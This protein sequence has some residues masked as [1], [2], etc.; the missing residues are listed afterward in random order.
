MHDWFFK[1]GRK[2]RLIDW[3]GI[4]DHVRPIPAAHRAMVIG[5]LSHGIQGA[6]RGAPDAREFGPFA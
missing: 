1:Q 6:P 4:D 2:R 5:E 3:L